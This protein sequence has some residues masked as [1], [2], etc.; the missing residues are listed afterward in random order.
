MSTALVLVSYLK[1][2]VTKNGASTEVKK[3]RMGGFSVLDIISVKRSYNS[4]DL[5]KLEVTVKRRTN[6]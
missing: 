4:G 3:E 2:L 5:S 1:K 6:T